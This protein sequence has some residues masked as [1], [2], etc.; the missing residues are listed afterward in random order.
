M[1][2]YII[3][4]LKNEKFPKIKGIN[5]NH[6]ESQIKQLLK[7][8]EAISV[9]EL[10]YNQIDKKRDYVLFTFDDGYKEHFHPVSELLIKY[11]I[12]GAFYIP[13]DPIMENKLLDVNKVHI[14]LATVN[15]NQILSRIKSL[16]DIHFDS[17]ELNKII[18]NIEFTSRYDNQQVEIIKKLLQTL[19]SEEKREF[20]LKKLTEE[21]FLKDESEIAKE[22]YLN[23]EEIKQMEGAGMHIGIHGKSHSRLSSLNYFEQLNEIESSINFLDKIYG[24]KPYIKTI[25]Y[26]YG[27]YNQDTL[28][29]LDRFDI[30][31]GFTTEPRAFCSESNLKTIPR[32]DTNDFK[33]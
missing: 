17:Q 29:I 33:V 13:V 22:W 16:Y 11:N 25:C 26:P 5:L 10:I 14:L 32:Y 9:E 1:Y 4:D 7:N 31:H 28:N 23:L 19:I 24:S 15:E 12:K 18:E 2:H 20:L 21:F 3:D 6:F 30:T 27:D 8:N